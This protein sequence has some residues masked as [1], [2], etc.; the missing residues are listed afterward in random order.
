M[1]IPEWVVDPNEQRDNVML[2]A[3]G[4]GG[5]EPRI[6]AELT[7][8]L[9]YWEKYLQQL[10]AVQLAKITIS[11]VSSEERKALVRMAWIEEE[12][13]RREVEHNRERV[14]R[15]SK[16]EAKWTMSRKGEVWL[17]EKACRG[18]LEAVLEMERRG[19]GSEEEH[20]KWREVNRKI[21]EN[22]KKARGVML[23]KKKK[24]EEVNTGKKELRTNGV[25]QEGVVKEEQSRVWLGE[26][27]E[28]EVTSAKEWND[29]EE[30][31]MVRAEGRGIERELEVVR[32]G[33]NPRIL[34]CRY[35]ELAS[36]RVCK[37]RVKSTNN[38]VKGMRFKMEEP[39]NE[40]EYL[41]TWKYEG[42]LPRV[43]GRW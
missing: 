43:K 1:E 34:V 13:R 23:A 39:N 15:Q 24:E 28:V 20:L 35:K 9:S 10:E 42:K 40:I 7:T 22:A 19:L 27:E 11:L 12:L 36:E 3:R 16:G 41:D 5:V 2:V 30:P 38:F 21:V 14:M 25:D 31:V 26:M 32:V 8:G 37:V 33:P 29:L 17:R 6:A 4:E 18:S